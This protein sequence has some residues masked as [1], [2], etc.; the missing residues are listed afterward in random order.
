[1]IF[2]FLRR[3]P[4]GLHYDL[5]AVRCAPRSAPAPTPLVPA[6]SF[7]DV[8]PATDNGRSGRIRVN[9]AGNMNAGERA[10]VIGGNWHRAVSPPG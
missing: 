6:K 10:F 9:S 4:V 7:I 1:M 2:P 3:C 5:P 8:Q